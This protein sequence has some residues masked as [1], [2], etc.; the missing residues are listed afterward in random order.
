MEGE[1]IK[2][3]AYSLSLPISKLLYEHTD[4]ETVLNEIDF[5]NGYRAV[6]RDTLAIINKT[7]SAEFRG[8]ASS[9]RRIF[10]QIEENEHENLVDSVIATCGLS[11][12]QASDNVRYVSKTTIAA[13]RILG[14][15]A[16]AVIPVKEQ[17]IGALTNRETFT[18]VFTEM[19]KSDN[20]LT[21]SGF[22]SAYLSEVNR[23][24]MS[25]KKE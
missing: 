12:Q 19:L 10:I 21:V 6:M 4:W 1:K 8:K 24:L 25:I 20:G 2:T 23:K 5:S 3:A 15:V 22:K 9:L 16:E 13:D 7:V 11:T 14:A 17:V 18:E